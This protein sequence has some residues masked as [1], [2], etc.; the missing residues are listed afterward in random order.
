[1]LNFE[2][3]EDVIAEGGAKIHETE[4]FKEE[5]RNA[6]M[7]DLFVLQT[8]IS[9]II[10]YLKRESEVIKNLIQKENEE[11]FFTFYEVE[12]KVKDKE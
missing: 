9:E 1:M 4:E 12:E 8:E 10:R 7:E 2:I 3:I 6:Q 5:L 11:M